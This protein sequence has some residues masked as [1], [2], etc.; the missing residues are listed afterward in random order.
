MSDVN[1][2]TAA[3]QPVHGERYDDLV[4]VTPWYPTETN[5]MWGTFV[6]D[7]VT[8][9]RRHH[10]GPVTVVHVD[11]TPVDDDAPEADRPLDEDGR[12]AS[13]WVTVSERPEARIVHVRAPMD[14]MTSRH[15]AIDVQRAAIVRHALPHIT[16]ATYVNAHVGAPTGAAV[17]PLLSRPARFVI[18]EHATYVRAVFADLEA[19]SAYRAAVARAQAVIA[20][21]DES[22]G[23]LRR[24]CGQQADIIRAVPNPVRFDDVPLRTEPMRHPDRWLYVGSLIERKGVD[25]LVESFAVAVSRDPQRPWHLTLVGDGP[26]HEQLVERIAELGLTDRVTF[27]GIVAPTEVGSYLRDADVLVHLSAY[28]TFGITLIEAVASG[29][30]VVVTK[31]G[32]PE[33]TM[34]LPE[35]VGMAVFVPRDP[36]PEAVADAVA[37]LRTDVG[38]AELTHVRGVLRGFYGEERV[39]DLLHTHV[40]G[41]PPPEP[42][43]RPGD[44]RVVVVYQGML[45]WRR[46]MHGVQRAIDMGAQVVAVDLESMTAG[47]VPK[48]MALVT[49]GDPDRYNTL[50]RVERAVVDRA[51]RTVLRGAEKVAGTLPSE[52]Q[53]QA[54][55]VLARAETF[56]GRVSRFS[57][58]QLYRRPWLLVRGLVMARRAESQPELYT[59]DQI[60]VIVHGGTRFTQLTYRLL[61]K[62]PE[63]EYHSGVFTAKHVARWWAEALKKADKVEPDPTPEAE[64]A[65]PAAEPTT[66]SP[67]DP[68]SGQATGMNAPAEGA[69]QTPTSDG[70]DGRPSGPAAGTPGGTTG[71]T[72]GGVA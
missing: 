59:A 60:D 40:L 16:Q 52:R 25:K 54:R 9:L 30:P 68:A 53:P 62:H 4:F 39:A 35:D 50:Q 55:K 8:T 2:L 51:P 37:A 7:A 29:L 1:P 28:E 45:Q 32:G 34:A 18:T 72:D 61:K 43:T 47:V 6:R 58:R 48:G 19:A 64:E 17:A 11:S 65:A 26:L 67:I 44:L 38:R 33:E 5:P 14:P 23:V 21:G 20:V 70:P 13:S 46:L 63:A 15:E 57:Q 3:A 56:H 10:T 31:C 69:T 71:T 12:P 49:V 36:E 41:D 27:A 42:F 66:A 24:Y 22:A